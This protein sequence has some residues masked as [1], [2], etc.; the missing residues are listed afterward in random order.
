MTREK[1]LKATKALDAID[2]FQSFMEDVDRAINESEVYAVM[3]TE[4][5]L[6]LVNLMEE[7]LARLNKVLA[8]L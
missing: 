1:A 5:K 3:S 2:G 7:E 4:F 6:A 8:D